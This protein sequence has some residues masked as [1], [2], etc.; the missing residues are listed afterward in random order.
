MQIVVGNRTATEQHHVP[1]ALHGK[2]ACY[3]PDAKRLYVDGH[4]WPSPAQGH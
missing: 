4:V 3:A 1:S 2:D